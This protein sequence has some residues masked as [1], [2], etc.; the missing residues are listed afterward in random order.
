[1]DNENNHVLQDAVRT[2][3]ALKYG[4][5]GPIAAADLVWQ[6]KKNIG[7]ILGS[8]AFLLIFARAFFVY[9]AVVYFRQFSTY[10]RLE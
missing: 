4:I 9:A 5:S 1:M 2:A 3:T 6:Q 10:V 7:M 8:T